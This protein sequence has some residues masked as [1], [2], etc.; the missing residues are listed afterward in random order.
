MKQI[1]QSCFTLMTTGFRPADFGR[2]VTP[3]SARPRIAL[4]GAK[5]GA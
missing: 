4:A 5:L 3:D 2:G 1:Y